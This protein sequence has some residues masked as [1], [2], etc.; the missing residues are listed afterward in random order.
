M[1]T[2]AELEEASN[3]DGEIRGYVLE[4]EQDDRQAVIKGRIEYTSEADK[5]TRYAFAGNDVTGEVPL[6]EITNLEETLSKMV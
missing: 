2:L 5:L 6:G 3:M 1:K 4:G